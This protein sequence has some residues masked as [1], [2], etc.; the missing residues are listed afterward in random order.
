MFVTSS[1]PAHWLVHLA[2]LAS[3]PV[4]AVIWN[5]CADFEHHGTF[6]VKTYNITFISVQDGSIKHG[7]KNCPN[8]EW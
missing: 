3:R 4:S 8:C 1:Q 6:P 2:Y 5:F 7:R